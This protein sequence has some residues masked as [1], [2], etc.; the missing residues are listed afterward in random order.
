MAEVGAEA[1]DDQLYR[2]SYDGTIVDET[3]AAF[4]VMGGQAESLTTEMRGE[5]RPRLDLGEALGVAVAALGSVGGVNGAAR[6][7]PA[8]Q[9]EVAVL[10]R[11]RGQRKFRRISSLALAEL[12]P[13]DR[14]DPPSDPAPADTPPHDEDGEA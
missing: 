5:F 3:A 14:G 13:A 8:S 9:L 4:L 7:L 12:L 1:A 2:L 10:D 6:S 11:A